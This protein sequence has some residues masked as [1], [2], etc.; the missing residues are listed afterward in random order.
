MVFGACLLDLAGLR[1]GLSQPAAVQGHLTQTGG[2][3]ARDRADK[4]RRCPLGLVELGEAAPNY[5][6]EFVLVHPVGPR[7]P[8]IL[9]RMAECVTG[10]IEGL[11]A[12]VCLPVPCVRPG[13]AVPDN[14][15]PTVGA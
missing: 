8:L 11:S 13:R 10:R 7:R 2:V 15:R 4:Q 3:V 9:V 6:L 5:H 1:V 12:Q 14:A